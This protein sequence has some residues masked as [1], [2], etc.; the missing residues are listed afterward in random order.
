ML[1]RSEGQNVRKGDILFTLDPAPFEATLRQAKATL[2]Q[3]QDAWN[4]VKDGPDPAQLA[5]LNARLADAQRKYER[6][7]NGPSDTDIQSAKARIVA[8]QATLSVGQLTAPFDGTI[9]EVDVM[10]GDLV[11]PGDLGYQIDDN[12]SQYVD[13]KV[14]EADINKVELGQ[15]AVL[16]FDGVPGKQYN[17]EVEKIGLVGKV[18][19]GAVD[20]IVSVKMTDAD[21]KVRQGMTVSANIVVGEKKDVLLVP[22]KAIRTV[23]NQSVIDVRRGEQIIPVVIQ[24]GLTSDTQTEILS[25]DVAAGDEVV[26]N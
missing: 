11:N 16:S 9:T 23:N 17:G 18:N 2:A 5:V 1:F 22:S 10:A 14:P 20:Y 25:G 6:V 26:V 4:K 13:L 7:K 12:T 24:V 19:S 15:P 3:A 21:S 8:D